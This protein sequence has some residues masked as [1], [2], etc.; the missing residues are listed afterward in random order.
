M[1]SATGPMPDF[2]SVAEVRARLGKTDARI[3]QMIAEGRLPAVRWG[4][5]VKIP[6]RAFEKW[7]ED[8]TAAAL[9]SV[10]G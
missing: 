4:R 9:A 5:A 2:M 1:T 7:I 3:Y 8:Q 6:R 10:Q